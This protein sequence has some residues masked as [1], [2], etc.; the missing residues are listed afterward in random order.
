METLALSIE[1]SSIAVD[2]ICQP[3]TPAELLSRFKNTLAGRSDL[4]GR[5]RGSSLQRKQDLGGDLHLNE[6]RFDYEKHSLLLQML[7]LQ[8]RG[9]WEVKGFWFVRG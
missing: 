7:R 4:L 2:S 9:T 8:A 5:F 3:T 1:L 6:Y